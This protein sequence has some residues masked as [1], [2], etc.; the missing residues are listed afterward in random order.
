M[1]YATTLFIVLLLSGCDESYE[2]PY[3]A[4][5]AAQYSLACVAQ[6]KD[7]GIKVDADLIKLCQE[8]G[9]MLYQTKES[10]RE[11]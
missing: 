7:A 8:G 2:S 5:R 4:N 9:R 11:P 6:A 3:R 1:K 10:P